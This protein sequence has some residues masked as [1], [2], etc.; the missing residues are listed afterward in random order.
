MVNQNNGGYAGS[1]AACAHSHTA[2][3]SSQRLGVLSVLSMETKKAP[4]PSNPKRKHGVQI[5]F[6]VDDDLAK[7]IDKAGE[8]IQKQT[9]GLEISRSEVARILLRK[10]LMGS[11]S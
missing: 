9:P 6:R 11:K 7:A 3:L 4:K 2:A 1:V 8:Q 5:A 10:A